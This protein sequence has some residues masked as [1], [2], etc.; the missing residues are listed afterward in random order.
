[1]KIVRK[2]FEFSLSRPH[3]L[4]VSGW[5]ANPSLPRGKA[6]F[7]FQLKSKKGSTEPFFGLRT[8]NN[9]IDYQPDLSTA[10]AYLLHG[11]DQ[12]TAKALFSPGIAVVVVA[13]LFP[14]TGLILSHKFQA[15]YPFGALP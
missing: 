5:T 12:K 3:N 11:V 14:K 7:V 2:K 4:E 15:A 10:R 13:I 1:M 6:S 8:R 9:S